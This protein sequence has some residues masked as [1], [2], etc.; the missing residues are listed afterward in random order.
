MKKFVTICEEIKKATAMAASLENG[1]AWARYDAAIDAF[2]DILHKYHRGE[3]SEAERDAAKAEKD[4]AK[5]EYLTEAENATRAK[6]RAEI[7]KDNAK[8]AFFAE[9]IGTIC[10]IWNKYAGKPYCKKT[11]DKIRDE[12]KAATGLYIYI[13]NR[14]SSDICI[15]ICTAAGCPVNNFE[16]RTASGCGERVRALDENNKI[17]PLAPEALRVWY[18]KEYI[19]NIDT[20]IKKIYKAHAAARDAMEK[21]AELCHVYNSLTRGNM[22]SAS[23][24]GGVKNY[25]I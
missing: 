14:Y 11:A 2:R 12:L 9:H 10:A 20:H 21:A 22:A 4:A 23:T 5:A 17:L 19:N 15:N 18:C 8:Q 7:L 3:A 13:Y 1:A 6:L 25:I 16:I 24:A